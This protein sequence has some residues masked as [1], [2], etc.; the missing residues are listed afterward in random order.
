LAIAS[1]H[2]AALVTVLSSTLAITASTDA[3]A[4]VTAAT[5][6]GGAS[7]A[8]VQTAEGVLGT[9]GGTAARPTGDKLAEPVKEVSASHGNVVGTVGVPGPGM[10][11][12]ALAPPHGAAVTRVLAPVLAAGPRSVGHALVGATRRPD[13]L[14]RTAGAALPQAISDVS[15]RASHDSRLSGTTSTLLE[16][17][18]QDARSAVGAEVTS[19]THALPGPS[20]TPH[21]GAMRLGDPP[22]RS[23]RR[24]RGGPEGA[25]QQSRTELPRASRSRASSS[26]GTLSGH[27]RKAIGQRSGA[28]R[29]GVPRFLWSSLRG[30]VPA[31][32]RSAAPMLDSIGGSPARS[33]SPARTNPSAPSPRPGV[34]SGSAG[35]SPGLGLPFVLGLAGLLLLA[36]TRAMRGLRLSRE[37]WLTAT[38]ALIPER[39]G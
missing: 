7:A 18:T 22:S 27:A 33:D 34:A 38:F 24:T 37:P 39:P 10:T 30:F 35:G 4:A 29:S 6:I 19:L 8:A 16:R 1:K 15:R 31:T 9:A 3:S 20:R 17:T 14:L 11:G 12:A 2:F 26:R 23:P 5:R 36:P 28:R 25:R 32:H 13:A 21:P